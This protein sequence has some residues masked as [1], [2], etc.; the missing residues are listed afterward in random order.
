MEHDRTGAPLESQRFIADCVARA[1]AMDG[2]LPE[3]GSGVVTLY[4]KTGGI[5]TEN[6]GLP[7]VRRYEKKNINNSCGIPCGM[8]VLARAVE[9]QR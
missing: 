2:F 5:P 3:K 9:A 8:C 1:M 4:P 7:G 6:G